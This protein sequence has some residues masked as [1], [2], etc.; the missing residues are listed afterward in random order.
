M[1]LKQDVSFSS[2][3]K[4]QMMNAYVCIY[5]HLHINLMILFVTFEEFL[6]LCSSIEMNLLSSLCK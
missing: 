1:T 6:Y 2:V 5:T 4:K 3:T